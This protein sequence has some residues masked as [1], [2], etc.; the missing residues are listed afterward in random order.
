MGNVIKSF[1]YVGVDAVNTEKVIN[2]V[3]DEGLS[4]S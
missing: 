4:M 2:V 1:T 3:I